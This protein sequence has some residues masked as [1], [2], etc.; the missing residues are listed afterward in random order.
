MPDTPVPAASTA[1]GKRDAAGTKNARSNGG[2]AS[3]ADANAATDVF[4]DHEQHTAGLRRSPRK[5]QSTSLAKSKPKAQTARSKSR[6]REPSVFREA[7]EAMN[8]GAVAGTL[9]AI[10]SPLV[11]YSYIYLHNT[12]AFLDFL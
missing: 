9:F 5:S 6:S 8:E 7:E 4:E 11:L 2:A 1:A 12:N 3:K 10:H